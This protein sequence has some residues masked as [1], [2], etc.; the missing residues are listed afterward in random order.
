M[1][2]LPLSALKHNKLPRFA[3]KNGFYRRRL[4][5]EFNDLTWTEEMV[6]AIYRT[7]V[8]VTRLYGPSEESD[9]YR[10]HGNTSNERPPTASFFPLPRSAP[11]RSPLAQQAIATVVVQLRRKHRNL[12]TLSTHPSPRN[13]VLSHQNQRKG[14]GARSRGGGRRR[15]RRGR[16]DRL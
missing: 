1:R 4:P 12:S 15:R 13:S 9:A 6:C 5:E 11:S 3:L 2:R 7:T 10:L 8:H 14:Q 16:L